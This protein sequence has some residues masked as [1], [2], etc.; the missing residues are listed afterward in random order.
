MIEQESCNI[1]P[2]PAPAE[3]RDPAKMKYFYVKN[4]MNMFMNHIDQQKH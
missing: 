2:D 3:C 1:S 4:A